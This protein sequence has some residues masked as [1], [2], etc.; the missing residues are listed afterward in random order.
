MTILACLVVLLIWNT[1]Q[2]HG[3]DNV[4]SALAFAVEPIVSKMAD[5][6]FAKA[7]AEGNPVA[8]PSRLL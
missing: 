3:D 5:P 6:A 8:V 7:Q 1:F 2:K 4:K